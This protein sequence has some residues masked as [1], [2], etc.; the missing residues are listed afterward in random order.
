MSIG[1]MMRKENR[2]DQCEGLVTIDDVIDLADRLL[3]QLQQ[4]GDY[5]YPFD[6]RRGRRGIKTMC[7]QTNRGKKLRATVKESTF[8]K[9]GQIY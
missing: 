8:E 1:K 4:L 6:I 3:K 7:D 2:E 5:K 9:N